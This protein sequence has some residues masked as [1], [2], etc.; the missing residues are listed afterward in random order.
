MLYLIFIAQP[1]FSQS[2]PAPEYQLKAAFLY[3]FTHFIDWPAD[4]FSS[5]EA[6]FVIGILGDDPFGPYI[7]EIVRG[8][9]H[10]SHPILV[11]RFAHV[12]DVRNCH[13]LYINSNEANRLREALPAINRRRILTV[14]DASN[15]ARWG[16]MI[17]FFKED[18]S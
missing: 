8:E 6:P 15:F 16:G 17:R 1:L 10:G 18:N 14:S 13:I 4:A 11:Q 5:S 12:K 3:N 7:D 2:R 9:R